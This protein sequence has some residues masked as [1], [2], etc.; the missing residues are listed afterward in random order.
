MPLMKSFG[1]ALLCVTVVSGSLL[2]DDPLPLKEDPLPLEELVAKV[3]PSVV[4]IRVQGRDGGRLGIG[5]GFIVDAQG[6]IATNYH[7]INEGRRFT[8]ETSDGK[9]LKVLAVEASDRVNDLALIRVKVGPA[10]SLVALPLADQRETT[11]GT[12]VAAFGNPL[13]LKD[14]VVDGIV[15]AIREV[16][17]RPMIQLAMPIEPGNSGGPLVDRQGRVLGIVNMK[18]AVDDNLGF[19]IPI[20]QLSPLRE[21]PNPVTIARWAR[22]GTI[23]RD[24]WNPIM[25]ATWQQR[26][27]VLTA[28]GLGNGFGG[29][30][31]CLSTQPT[32]ELPFELAVTVKLDDESGAAGLAF[33]SDGQDKHYGFYPSNGQMRLTCFKGPSVYS[34]EV[35]Q[36]LASQDYLAG[37]WNRLR[38]RIEEGA[39]KCFVNDQLVITASDQQLTKGSLGLV[40]FRNTRPEF[41]NFLV[42]TDLRTKPLSESATDWL[43][44]LDQRQVVPSEMSDE[45]LSELGRSGEA[46]ARALILRAADMDRQAE[47]LRQLANEVKRSDVLT[48]LSELF[49]AESKPNRDNEERLLSATL[50]VAQLDNPEMDIDHY[51]QRIAAMATDI[52][53]SLDDDAD[54]ATKLAALND[55][56]F[57]QN[58]F[59]GG[60]TEYYHPANSH[61][62]RV[63]DDREG[64]PITLAI[65][66]MELGRRLG[67]VISGIGLPG[68][69]I[70]RAE[71][72]DG[73][74]EGQLIDAFEGG[75]FVSLNEAGARVMRQTGRPI[76]DAD[77]RAQS[78]QEIVT[79]V[80]SNLMGIASRNEDL[81]SMLR[82][83]EGSLAIN[84]QAVDF[85]VMRAQLRGM[86][87][88]TTRAIADIDYLLKTR[89]PGI[90]ASRLQ[91]LR[92][93]I[94]N[95]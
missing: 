73:A 1:F 10:S 54:R 89:P 68:H 18:S 38:V 41:R 77:L 87:G 60:R 42:G 47:Q 75:K 44:K 81:E 5:T 92:S 11:Q 40:K 63:I 20:Q 24:Q 34:W 8:V 64:L 95:Q 6:L 19:A 7:V 51:R 37:Q 57:Q 91:Q 66:Y 71:P 72:Q 17:G 88:R 52:R 58:G 69:F 28:S 25:G 15:S 86:T 36:D 53:D 70:V 78:D 32:P 9:K 21:S 93:A 22:L 12:R 46:T 29:R 33:F 84:P 56:L 62:N 27:G 94:E 35:L 49:D 23:N 80:L 79:R 90:D 31:L 50:L 2:A 39:I 85:R 82:Y 65:L 61:L 55:Y 67:V 83:L 14:S 3:R 59:H 13:G 4:T 48:R 30:S 76:N 45:E 43:A 74:K 26:G 16:Q